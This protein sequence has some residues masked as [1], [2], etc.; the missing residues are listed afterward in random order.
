MLREH[1]AV[2]TRQARQPG[3]RRT[4]GNFLGEFTVGPDPGGFRRFAVTD[5]LAKRPGQPGTAGFGRREQREGLN[6]NPDSI[7]RRE[8]KFQQLA[9]RQGGAVG[10]DGLGGRKFH[11]GRVEVTQG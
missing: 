6:G 8:R 4:G 10:V 5:A 9:G 1:G 7:Q 2:G 3:E 11:R